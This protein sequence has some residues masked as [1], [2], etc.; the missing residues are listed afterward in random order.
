[1][2]IKGRLT[3]GIIGCTLLALLTPTILNAQTADYGTTR[4]PRT[5]SSLAKP[6]QGKLTVEQAKMYF[7][8]DSE[9]EKTRYSPSDIGSLHLIDDLSLKISPKSRPF[10]STDLKHNY[11]HGAKSAGMD[12]DRPI[13]D[14]RGS[15]TSYTC[16][17]IGRGFKAGK[18]CDSWRLSSAG[19]CFLDTFGEWHC[20]MIGSGSRDQGIPAPEKWNS[21]Q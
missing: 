10:N 9:R 8:C 18:N 14:I 1:M 19:I 11:Y 16:F 15:Y 7:T 21:P 3:L 12:P 17:E 6:Q 13:Y 5:C 20:H 2:N 4:R